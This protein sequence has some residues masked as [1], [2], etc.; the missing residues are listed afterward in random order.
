MDVEFRNFD[1]PSDWGVV[2]KYMPLKRVDD[3]GGIVAVDKETNETVGIV[4]MDSWTATSVQ[5]HQ[6]IINPMVL[7]HGFFEEVA[8]YVFNHA[9]RELMIGLVPSNNAKAL[10]MNGK[11]GFETAAVIPDGVDTGVDIVIMTMR[12]EQCKFWVPPPELK[13]AAN[14][15]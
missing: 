13:E 4:V 12:K 3:T 11:I 8:E 14:G 15:R 2:Q 1:G 9:G 10:Q 5:I 6:I 7:R